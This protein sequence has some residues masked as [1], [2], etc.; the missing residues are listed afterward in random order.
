MLWVGMVILTQLLTTFM[1]PQKISSSK[2][3]VESL[4]QR[5]RV[6]RALQQRFQL[7]IDSRRL[8]L[9]EFS[10]GGGKKAYPCSVRGCPARILRD[11]LSKTRA[12]VFC[13]K[14][15]GCRSNERQTDRPRTE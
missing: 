11:A 12:S 1:R 6:L 8:A 15:S 3:I 4:T 14:W 5:S 2:L 13:Q 7:R 10:I 9:R